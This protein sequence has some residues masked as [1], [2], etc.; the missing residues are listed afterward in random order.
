M[1]GTK[2]W[3]RIKEDVN[4]AS[5]AEGNPKGLHYGWP[6]RLFRGAVLDLTPPADVRLP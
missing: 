1:D 3:Y 6:I 5:Y 2:L 4:V